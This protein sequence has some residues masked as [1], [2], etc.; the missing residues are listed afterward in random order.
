MQKKWKFRSIKKTCAKKDTVRG[1]RWFAEREL[2]WESEMENKTIAGK[3]KVPVPTESCQAL[4]VV[5]YY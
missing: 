2:T 3:S 5:G 1:D 4:K